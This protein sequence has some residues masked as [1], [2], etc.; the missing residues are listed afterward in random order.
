MIEAVATEILSLTRHVRDGST[1]SRIPNFY[2]ILAP[3]APDNSR[4]RN[5]AFDQPAEA[6]RRTTA[7]LPYGYVVPFSETLPGKRESLR[8]ELEGY[9]DLPLDWDDDDGHAPDKAD[10][11]NAI[12]FM[13]SIPSEGIFSAELMVAGDGDVGFEWK[14]SDLRLEVGFRRGNISFFGEVPKGEEMNGD[15]LFQGAVPGDL[16]KFMNL[17]FVR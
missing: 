11:D 9:A 3:D 5:I 1:S 7:S 16:V 17:V 4:M 12:K 8:R 10:I 15:A 2:S 6:I 14:T 13:D